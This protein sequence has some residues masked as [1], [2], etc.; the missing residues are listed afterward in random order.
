MF[1][2][3]SGIVIAF[4]MRMVDGGMDFIIYDGREH[5]RYG[6]LIEMVDGEGSFACRG[7]IDHYDNF[8][9]YVCRKLGFKKAI[10]SLGQSQ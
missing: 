7:D 1:P 5:N 4:V 3:S 8:H 10:V 6:A 2:G 9:N